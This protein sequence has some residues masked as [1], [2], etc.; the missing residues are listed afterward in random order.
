ME[1]GY[2]VMH[3]KQRQE[4]LLV[5]LAKHGF[6]SIRDLAERLTVS[7]MTV[8]RD[9]RM[10]QSQGLVNQVTGGGQVAGSSSEQP[11]MAKR[12]LQQAEKM[13]IAKTAMPL[14][15]PQMTIGLSAGT[16][17]W[18]LAN[19]ITGFR[20]LTFVT[21]ST[22][23]AIEL[24][25]NGWQDIILT[26]GHFRTPSDALV[27]PLAE[28]TVRK[29]HMDILFLGVHGIDLVAGISTPNLLEASIDRLLME[30][31][32]KVILLFDHSK[33]GVQAL[34]HIAVID[35]VDAVV[36][37]DAGREFEISAL[38]DAGVEVFLTAL[39]GVKN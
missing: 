36:T 7:E 9:L 39:D 37:D 24:N 3:P 20:D 2:D 12:L 15:E 8:R 28:A 31:A 17:T 25:H 13:W 6:I 18:T 23:I 30:R 5:L 26:G 16:T 14:I 34:A 10:L 32:D 1:K 21:N 19:A 38:R 22:N 11:F 4:M 29:V 35:E 27:G 33:W